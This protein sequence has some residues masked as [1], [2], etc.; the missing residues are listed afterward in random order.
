MLDQ[1]VSKK[2]EEEEEEQDGDVIMNEDGTMYSGNAQI[3][4]ELW[5]YET[6]TRTGTWGLIVSSA[7]SLRL[8]SVFELATLISH[9][10]IPYEDCLYLSPFF[11]GNIFC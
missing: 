10:P 3:E 5:L 1:F 8:G 2:V 9:C 6:V 7:S 4:Y 11:V